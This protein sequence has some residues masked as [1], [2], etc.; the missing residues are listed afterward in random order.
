MEKDKDRI[1]FDLLHKYIDDMG[2]K[3][4][5]EYYRA[6]RENWTYRARTSAV[7]SCLNRFN[8]AFP[9]YAT[10][11][12]KAITWDSTEE[13]YEYWAAIQLRF[14]Y[15]LCRCGLGSYSQLNDFYERVNRYQG[16]EG[17]SEESQ[18]LWL[19]RKEMK[20]HYGR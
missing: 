19:C 8:A 16:G 11:F 9:C 18:L 17:L 20:R 12:D 2:L 5:M 1:V 4:K 3:D 15:C 6:N 13:G 14:Y 7:W 10:F